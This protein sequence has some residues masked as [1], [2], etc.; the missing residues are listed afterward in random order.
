[1]KMLLK[2]IRNAYSKAGMTIM[3]GHCHSEPSQCHSGQ[4]QC[5]PRPRSGTQRVLF[6]LFALFFIMAGLTGCD[7]KETKQHYK[8]RIVVAAKKPSSTHLY[9]NGT[10]APIKMLSVTSPADGRI[11]RIHFEYGGKID[12]GQ[13]IVSIDSQDLSEKFRTAISD[14]LTTKETLATQRLTFQG[15]TALY[16]AGIETRNNFIS[17]RSQYETAEMN[18]YQKRLALEKI[19]KQVKIPAA[20]FE[21][22]T[23]SDTKRVNAALSYK[24]KN[25]P[26]YAEGSGVALFPVS[27]QGQSNDNSS[28]DD[29][30][31]V[32]SE[33]KQGQLI[34]SIGDLSG[35]SVSFKVGE[36]DINRLHTGLKVV[37][38]GVSFPKQT[39]KGVVSSVASQADDSSSSR[40]LSEFDVTVKIPTITAA[41]RKVVHI[42]MTSKVDIEIENPPSIMIPINA[43]AEKNGQSMVTVV[44]KSGARKSVPVVTGSTTLNS[45]TIVSGITEGQKV[46]VNDPV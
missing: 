32:G 41:Q 15:T 7:K 34:L 28:G 27:D 11:A 44:T 5:H 18:F 46:V 4:S 17:G 31:T 42:G 16:K 39:L 33:V 40:A 35:L 22:L 12:K 19:L 30:L 1:M 13:E 29:R 3:Q 2:K 26:V 23:I 36:V 10:I 21:N 24:F 43:V 6:I 8:Q 38:S 37:V 45:V 25:I 20:Q 14:Y 9:Y